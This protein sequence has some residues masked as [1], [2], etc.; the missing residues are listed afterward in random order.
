MVQKMSELMAIR[1]DISTRNPLINVVKKEVIPH[2]K[3]RSAR[4]DK[5]RQN[6]ADAIKDENAINLAVTTW[7]AEKRYSRAAYLIFSINGGLRYGDNVSLRVKDVFDEHGKIIDG[8]CLIEGKTDVRRSVYIN[9]AMKL[10]LEFMVKY[11]NLQPDDFIF[12]ADGNRRAY[13]ESFV[14]DEN[15][16]IVDVKTTGSKYDEYGK[17]RKR[18]PITTKT[19]CEWYAEMERFGA[20]GHFSSHSGRNTFRYFISKYGE[21]ESYEDIVL[22]SQC[23]GHASVRTTIEHYC[24]VSEE[25]KRNAANSL[26]L[27]LSAFKESLNYMML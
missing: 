27:G 14:Y 15:G 5:I 2:G 8:F 24:K 4:I 7:C 9:E 6:S 21:S 18:A 12:T 25:T 22:A 19:A 17:I 3:L 26:N 16:D 11:K 20:K 1:H 13:F 23:L 10:V